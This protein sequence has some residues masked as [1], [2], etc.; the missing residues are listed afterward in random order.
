MIAVVTLYVRICI[1]Y[2]CMCSCSTYVHTNIRMY[3]A[4]DAYIHI[5]LLYVYRLCIYMYV[6]MHICIA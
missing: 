5:I 3:C 4:N 6:C 2:L 1:I